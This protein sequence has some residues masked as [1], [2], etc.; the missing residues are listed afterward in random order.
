MKLTWQSVGARQLFSF[1]ISSLSFQRS[2]SFSFALHKFINK[3]ISRNEFVKTS[4]DKASW[5]TDPSSCKYSSRFS[6][7]NHVT[8]CR[9]D[10]LISWWKTCPWKQ[11][12]DKCFK[13]IG[14]QPN[15]C[16]QAHQGDA[17]AEDSFPVLFVL[18]QRSLSWWISLF[19]FISVFAQEN[20]M[21][22][23][24]IIMKRNFCIRGALFF[25]FLG[26]AYSFS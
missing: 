6:G 23:L 7:N 13:R 16:F 2:V 25:C 5:S 15:R 11:R 10:L 14:V 8:P 24:K 3:I 17:S 18:N 20:Y 21:Q 4:S 12:G 9:L 22:K 26:A 1:I 19:F